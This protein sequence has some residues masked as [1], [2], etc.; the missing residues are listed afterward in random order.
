MTSHTPDARY[1]E[2]V[3]S[4]VALVVLAAC[5]PQVAAAPRTPVPPPL[6]QPGTNHGAEADS[7]AYPAEQVQR[8]LL[9]GPA[10]EDYPSERIAFLTF[11]DGPSE[12]ATPAVLD[13][14]A[15][16]DV[17]ATFFVVTGQD[18]LDE[19]GAQLVRRTIAE[20]NAVCL[21][22]ASHDY[23]YLYPGGSADPDHVLA[24]QQEM[25]ASLRAALGPEY[26]PGC[27]RYPGGHMSWRSMAAADEALAGHGLS[28][29]DWN[30]MT[31]DSAGGGR[32]PATAEA[33]AAAVRRDVTEADSPHVLVVLM[34]DARGKTVSTQ[35]LPRIVADL[36]AQGYSFGVIS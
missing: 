20:G 22:S 9:E 24:D 14:L 19:T 2:L 10:A 34:H 7:Y 29:I 26:A 1:L 11:D 21:H 32:A 35:A 31:G 13:A 18:G 5:A 12:D 8:W 25:L 4:T 6:V 15:A 28:W 17:P 36:R 30:A 16:D 33:A 3:L 23:S 27:F